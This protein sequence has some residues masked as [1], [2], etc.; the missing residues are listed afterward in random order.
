MF[1]RPLN[2]SQSFHYSFD[3]LLVSLVTLL[4]VL[5]RLELTICYLQYLS[6]FSLISTD[7]LVWRMHALDYNMYF[8]GDGDEVFNKSC[9]HASW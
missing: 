4:Y 7:V 5:A 9:V 1:L 8:I 6:V 2:C 3:D